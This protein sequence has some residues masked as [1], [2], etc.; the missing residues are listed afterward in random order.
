M[1]RCRMLLTLAAA[2]ACRAAGGAPGRA[3]PAVPAEHAEGRLEYERRCAGCHGDQ[4]EGTKIAPSLVAPEYHAPLFSDSAFRA[5]VLEGINPPRPPYHRM[6]MPA[7]PQLRG[8][9]EAMIRR[10]VRWMQER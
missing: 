8:E 1:T 5:A 6:P 10:Y 7:M 4:L 2:L 9:P 3:G